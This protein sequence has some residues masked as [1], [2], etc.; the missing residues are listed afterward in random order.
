MK[1]EKVPQKVT[2]PPSESARVNEWISLRHS[3]PR[4]TVLF[5]AVGAYYETYFEDAQRVSKILGTALTKRGGSLM[6]GIPRHSVDLYREK[7]REAKVG[8]IFTIPSVEVTASLAAHSFL[9]G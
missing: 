5:V 9:K 2:Y 3:A 7:L 6:T 8:A 1:T 4:G